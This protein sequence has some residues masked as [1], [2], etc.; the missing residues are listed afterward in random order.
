MKIL[1]VAGYAESLI[2]FRFELIKSLI[3]S[4]YEVCVAC[5]EVDPDTEAKLLQK[6]VSVYDIPLQRT[7]VNP[8]SDTQALLALVKL[9]RGIKP[10]VFLAYT[11]K[12]VI[13]GLLAAGLAKVPK[14]FALIT[15]LGYAFTGKAVGLRGGIRKIVQIL[16]KTALNKADVVF[17]SKSG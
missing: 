6:G 9:M 4:G 5:P 15:G 1:I 7:G 13:Y 11:I 8:V 17:F 10:D 14:R 2:R 12:P 3:A 16:Y